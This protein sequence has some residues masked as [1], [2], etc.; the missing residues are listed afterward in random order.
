LIIGLAY[1]LVVLRLVDKHD[2]IGWWLLLGFLAGLGWW[3]NPQILYLFVPGL[4]WLAYKLRRDMKWIAVA[5]LP[6][7]LGALP[8]LVWNAH[9]DWGAL[10]PKSHQFDK[11]YVGNIEVL[12]RHGVPV[13]LGFNVIERWLVPVLFPAIYVALLVLGTIGVIVRPKKPWL[14]IVV[15]V[16]Y[17]LLWGLYPNTGVIGEGRY[18]L[19]LGP[20][21]VLLL[22][23]AAKHPLFQV[24]LLVGALGVSIDGVHRIT[25]CVEPNAPDVAMP[26]STKP[27]IRELE[28]LH[29]DAFYGDYWIAFRVAFETNEKIVGCPRAFKRWPDYCARA[30]AQKP[31]TFVFVATSKYVQGFERGLRRLGI[32]YTKTQ[33]GDFFVF[34]SNRQTDVEPV[35][36]AGSKP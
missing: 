35:L 11:G 24:L 19:F 29:V 21:F 26:N 1:L 31:S 6:A 33:A 3:T 5:I 36:A 4:V 27:L 13:M 8:W 34:Q 32:G 23:H 14:L 25:C 18:V 22:M 12:V 7:I 17:P 30:A 28:G 15:V 20:A 16:M 9:H 2:A 10:A